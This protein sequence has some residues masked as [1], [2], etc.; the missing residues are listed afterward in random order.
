MNERAAQLARDAFAQLKQAAEQVEAAVTA[1]RSVVPV[2]QR[3]KAPCWNCGR[4]VVA[5]AKKCDSCGYSGFDWT[6]NSCGSRLI[7]THI[8]LLYCIRCNGLWEK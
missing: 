5:G 6:C 8:G 7:E 2:S 1:G 3:P 4:L